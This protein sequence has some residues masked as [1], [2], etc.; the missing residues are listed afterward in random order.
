MS[1]D[2][3]GTAAKQDQSVGQRLQ[4]GF[5][6]KVLVPLAV[7]VVSAAASYL[8]RK[9]PLIIEERVLPML[10]EQGGGAEPAPAA[11]AHGADGAAP[12][13]DETSGASEP[14]DDETSGATEA[15]PSNEEREEERRGREERRRERKRAVQKS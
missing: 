3:V 8:V 12:S 15:E 5:E 9:L 2:R 11:A 13:N 7:T 1:D 4:R 14:G 6:S 10:R